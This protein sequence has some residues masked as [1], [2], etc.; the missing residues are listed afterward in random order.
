MKDPDDQQF[1]KMLNEPDN[2]VVHHYQLSTKR[3]LSSLKYSM[4]GRWANISQKVSLA[5]V[6]IMLFQVIQRKYFFPEAE[7]GGSKAIPGRQS[8][9]NTNSRK[10]K[11]QS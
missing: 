9:G 4:N 2:T 7:K 3:E 5:T 6:I 10:Y 1:V 11:L 8:N